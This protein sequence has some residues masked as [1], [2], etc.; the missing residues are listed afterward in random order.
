MEYFQLTHQLVLKGSG[1]KNLC[2]QGILP[3]HFKAQMKLLYQV[4][5]YSQSNSLGYSRS[6]PHLLQINK[7]MVRQCL[8]QTYNI[9][10]ESPHFSAF[11][12]VLVQFP[13]NAEAGNAFLLFLF[14]HSSKCSVGSY[15]LIG[16][17]TLISSTHLQHIH[18][19]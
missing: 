8:I 4:R 2:R 13:G 5:R 17:I 1:K 14:L 16:V 10:Q 12:Q 11:C 7:S 3:Y 15:K 19:S 9:H 18:H 6:T